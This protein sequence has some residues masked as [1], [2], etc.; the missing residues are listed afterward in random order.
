MQL[1]YSKEQTM[2][3][4]VNMEITDNPAART[5]T[6]EL[7][8]GSHLKSVVARSIQ[9]FI[10]SFILNH[11]FLNAVLQTCFAFDFIYL[12]ALSCL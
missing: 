9:V 11:C 4:V 7:I 5:S 8:W 10:L 6:E 2:Q 12:L 1:L 3:T